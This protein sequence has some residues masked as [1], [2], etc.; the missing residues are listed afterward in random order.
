MFTRRTMLKTG[1]AAG[2]ALSMPWVARAAARTLR[3][4]HAA[5]E[6]HPGHKIATS[7]AEELERLVPGAFDVQIFPNRQLGDDKQG[8]ESVLSGTIEIC[9]ASGVQYPLVTGRPALDA[10]QLPFLVRDYDHFSELSKTDIAQKIHDDLAEAGLIGLATAD[11]GQRHFLSV[12][13]SVKSIDHF[14]GLKTRIVPVPLHKAVWEAVGVS[15]VGLPYG[16][17]Y[18]AL[19]TKVI[20]AVEI[21]VSSML[22]ENLFEVGK[23][24]TLTGHYPWH[25]TTAMNK[26]VFDALEPD[27]QGAIR[28]AGKHSTAA[29]LAY[30]KEQD[31]TGRDELRKKG[32]DIVELEDLDK[33]KER[34]APLVGQ[35]S[36]KSPLIAEFVKAA[37]A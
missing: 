33:V 21:N 7:F 28:E 16:E 5:A 36:E 9:N 2:V 10:Y 25:A 37:M 23:H 26:A 29:T 20:D 35:W 15:P 11:I 6:S 24:M 12:R 22:G 14:A 3:F 17:V 4:A 19:E 27:F 30:A 31:L 32:V 8:L 13:D 34:V 18:G 1:L